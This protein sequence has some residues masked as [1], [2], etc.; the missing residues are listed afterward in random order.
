MLNCKTPISGG[1]ASSWPIHAD[2]NSIIVQLELQWQLHGSVSFDVSYRLPWAVYLIYIQY[3]I[4]MS[5][6]FS[7][8]DK[9]NS[10]CSQCLDLILLRYHHIYSGLLALVVAP[11]IWM[12]CKMCS[13]HI[14]LIHLLI[15]GFSFMES[16]DL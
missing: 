2:C 9:Y 12:A 14:K 8:C 7:W 11:S 10:L 5:Q 6:K 16:T 3:I 4:T 13:I 15:T 1:N